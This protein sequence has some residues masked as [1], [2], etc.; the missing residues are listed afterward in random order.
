MLPSMTNL[1]SLGKRFR[2]PAR[3]ARAWPNPSIRLPFPLCYPGF[4]YAFEVVIE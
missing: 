4:R 2:N 3:F 1:K